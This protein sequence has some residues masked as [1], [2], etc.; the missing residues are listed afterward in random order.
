MIHDTEWV[1]ER[2]NCTQNLA[3]GFLMF[4]NISMARLLV[5]GSQEKEHRARYVWRVERLQSN[6]LV[7]RLTISNLQL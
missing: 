2:E 1:F 3:V 7:T 5:Q 4:V 6:T